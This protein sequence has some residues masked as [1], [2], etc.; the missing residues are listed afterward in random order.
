MEQG[1]SGIPIACMLQEHVAA[2]AVLTVSGLPFSSCRGCGLPM[3]QW[4]REWFVIP[5]GKRLV[6]NAA[7]AAQPEGEDE[8]PSLPAVS[9]IEVRCGKLPV[10]PEARNV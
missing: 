6:W 1:G 4:N 7:G 8:G 2:E 10:Q 9:S 3:I 5:R